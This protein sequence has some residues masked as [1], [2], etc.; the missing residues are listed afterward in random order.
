MKISEWDKIEKSINEYIDEFTNIT[1]YQ[2]ENAYLKESICY[3]KGKC[4]AYER[5]LLQHKLIK[6]NQ[7]APKPYF[8]K[9]K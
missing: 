8:L 6:P 1:K 5:I 9:G 3:L 2:S 4:D 7:T